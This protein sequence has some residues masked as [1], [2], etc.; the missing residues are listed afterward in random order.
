[1]MFE[2]DYED[3]VTLILVHEDM[4]AAETSAEPPALPFPLLRAKPDIEAVIFELVRPRASIA[5]RA[6][7]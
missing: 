2:L 3:D 6:S 7:A 1:M 5:P 4:L